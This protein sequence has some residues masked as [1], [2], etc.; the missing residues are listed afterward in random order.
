MREC[1]NV[2][3]RTKPK[4]HQSSDMSLFSSGSVFLLRLRWQRVC[5]REISVFGHMIVAVVACVCVSDATAESSLLCHAECML[6]TAAV[7]NRVA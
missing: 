3:A 2:L 1:P 6:F 4:Y 7:L 5:S